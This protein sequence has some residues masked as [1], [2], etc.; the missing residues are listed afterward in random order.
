MRL[1]VLIE[2][3]AM[4]AG[5]FISRNLVRLTELQGVENSPGH[6]LNHDSGLD[7]RFGC[8]PDCENA[9]VLLTCSF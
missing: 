4:G 2:I 8:F 6:I 7:G 5:D 1:S 9:V 3:A